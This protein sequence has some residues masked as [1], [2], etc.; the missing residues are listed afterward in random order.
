MWRDIL[1]G[2]WQRPSRD[3]N[4]AAEQDKNDINDIIQ[5]EQDLVHTEISNILRKNGIN[6]TEDILRS[7]KE[8]LQASSNVLKNRCSVMIENLRQNRIHD[9]KQRRKDLFIPLL[10][11]AIIALFTV[12][13]TGEWNKKNLDPNIGIDIIGPQEYNW[14]VTLGTSTYLSIENF[15]PSEIDDI[16]IDLISFHATFQPTTGLNDIVQSLS[17]YDFLKIDKLKKEK[18]DFNLGTI[19]GFDLKSLPAQYNQYKKDSLRKQKRWLFYFAAHYR[20]HR[21]KRL[22]HTYSRLYDL[23]QSDLNAPMKF[24]PWKFESP[25]QNFLRSL[26][27]P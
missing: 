5:N 25:D 27:N 13:L 14:I 22:Y 12:W 23:G 24:F 21:T 2:S 7:G 16:K 18:K 20:H 26:I 9:Q 6:P 1:Q 19:P 17:I 4:K 8:I 11:G 3:P 10:S 15:G